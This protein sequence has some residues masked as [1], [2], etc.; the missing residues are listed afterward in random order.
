MS[1]L[2]AGPKVNEML[3]QLP[4][5]WT[6]RRGTMTGLGFSKGAVWSR[7]SR[8]QA[9]RQDSVEKDSSGNGDGERSFGFEVE[10]AAEGSSGAKLIIRWIKG[11]DSVMFESFCGMLKRKVE[12]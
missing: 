4:M 9:S 11:H 5:K 3:T 12:G 2:V 10:V 7:A 8:R 1:P 6:W